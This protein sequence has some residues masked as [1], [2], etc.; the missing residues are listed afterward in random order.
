MKIIRNIRELYLLSKRDLA[1]LLGIDDR[2]LEQY[3][4]GS[5]LP[6]FTT[7]LKIANVLRFSIDYIINNGATYYLKNLRLLELA[8]MFDTDI[9]Y[10]HR[11]HLEQTALTF[12][13]KIAD[14]T[15][16]I[17]MDNITADLTDNF[18]KNLKIVRELKKLSQT[19][20]GKD[21]GLSPQVIYRYENN[22]FPP[23]EK[24]KVISKALNISA[25]CLCTGEK[26]NFYTNDSHFCKTMILA[27]HYLPLKEHAMLI[28]LME[29]LLQNAGIDPQKPRHVFT[30]T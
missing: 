15:E 8:K 29:T 26:L 11:N 3:E 14:K 22:R 19:Q 5:I 24:L 6:Y 12:L 30:K 23:S 10:T 20:L 1:D 7:L 17:L 9:M 2:T 27:D 18:R 28:H 4:V 13:N 25:H 16:N 21:C